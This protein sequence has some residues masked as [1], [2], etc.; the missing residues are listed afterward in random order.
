MLG[1][2]FP[3]GT[4]AANV[5]GSF[6]IGFYAMQAA[7]GGHLWASPEARLFVMTGFCGGFTTFSAFSL[8][9]LLLLESGRADLAAGNIALSLCL[10]LGAVRLGEWAG[11]R[12]GRPAQGPLR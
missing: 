8:E 1:E 9:T 10:W 7:R 6:I 5:L 12:L 3:W 4:L 2:G 11:R